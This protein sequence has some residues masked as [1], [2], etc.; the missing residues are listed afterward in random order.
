MALA[1]LLGALSGVIGFS[2]L[3]IGLRLTKKTTA[4]TAFSSMAVLI[5]ALVVSFVLVFACTILFVAW[6]KPNGFPFVLAEVICLCV[7]AIGYG[8]YKNLID[9]KKP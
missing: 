2:P 9:A 6:D 5:L 7:V 3:L 8:I 1:I 4:T